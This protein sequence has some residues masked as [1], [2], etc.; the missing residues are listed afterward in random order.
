MWKTQRNLSLIRGAADKR[1]VSYGSDAGEMKENSHG[2]GDQNPDD[3]MKFFPYQGSDQDCDCEKQSFDIEDVQSGD[4]A[5]SQRFVMY[6]RDLHYRETCGGDQSDR[7][8]PETVKTPLY[9]SAFSE[10]LQDFGDDEN[11]DDS[12]S[13]Q[14][15]RGDDGAG[16]RRCLNS[17]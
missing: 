17:T 6:E 14:S 7:R 12:G 5:L 8:R 13:D 4:P 9:I 15:Q 16:Q 10:F 1:T 3:G 2:G 11:D